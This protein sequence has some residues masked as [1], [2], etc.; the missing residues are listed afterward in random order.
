MKNTIFSIAFER[1]IKDFFSLKAISMMLII[2]FIMIFG[3]IV[4]DKHN[5]NTIIEKFEQFKNK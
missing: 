4:C 1:P 2:G 5:R 3:T